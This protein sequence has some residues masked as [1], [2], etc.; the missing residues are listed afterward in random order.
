VVAETRNT[1]ETRA[2]DVQFTSHKSKNSC[3]VIHESSSF[4]LESEDTDLNKP[5]EIIP[6]EDETSEQC[7]VCDEV[8]RSKDSLKFHIFDHMPK[9]ELERIFRDNNKESRPVE[10][11]QDE[12]ESSKENKACEGGG[13]KDEFGGVGGGADGGSGDAATGDGGG[14]AGPAGDAGDG[15]G[16]TCGGEGGAGG[17]GVCA[18]RVGGESGGGGGAFG[19]GGASG[20]GGGAGGGGGVSE[21]LRQSVLVNN[22]EENLSWTRSRV[23][24]DQLLLDGFILTINRGPLQR[25]SGETVIYFK[26]V[27]NRPSRGAGG[28]RVRCPFTAWTLGGLLTRG[29]RPHCHPVDREEIQRKERRTRLRLAAVTS[30]SDITKL[31]GEAMRGEEREEREEER[32]RER[33]K[34]EG[35]ELSALK[36]VA[37]RQKRRLRIKGLKS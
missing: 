3:E 15:G 20:G 31:V 16:G 22:P 25:K 8:F 34:R 30:F 21:E 6:T 33:E 14:G 13:S 11:L 1:G 17:G 24:G 26:C 12:S 7:N 2:Q 27:K 32:D 19:E 9:E 18:V 37:R 5:C 36:Q 4:H 10:G 35:R 28:E 23:G 29:G